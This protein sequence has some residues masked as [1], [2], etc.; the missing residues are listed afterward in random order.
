MAVRQRPTITMSMTLGVGRDDHLDVDDLAV[1]D[2]VLP[3]V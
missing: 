3:S 2:R 1:G